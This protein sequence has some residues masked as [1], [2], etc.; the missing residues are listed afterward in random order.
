MTAA[1]SPP[2]LTL[3]QVITA[4]LAHPD[5]LPPLAPESWRVLH[6]LRTCRTPALTQFQAQQA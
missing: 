6:A 3:A 1:P 2:D 4:A 5:S